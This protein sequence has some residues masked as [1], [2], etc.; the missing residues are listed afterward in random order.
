[1]PV[2]YGHAWR[3]HSTFPEGDSTPKCQCHLPP[4]RLCEA[5]CFQKR[6]ALGCLTGCQPICSLRLSATVLR[7]QICQDPY[8]DTSP[9]TIWQSA[10]EW[11]QGR[12]DSTRHTQHNLMTALKR[13]Q[14]EVQKQQNKLA[15]QGFSLVEFDVILLALLL[16]ISIMK[17]NQVNYLIKIFS[18]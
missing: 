9:V 1:M 4:D 10:P 14:K 7:G 3:R 16:S 8:V 6:S 18:F 2:F 11:R 15:S 12:S 17:A 5:G 13:A